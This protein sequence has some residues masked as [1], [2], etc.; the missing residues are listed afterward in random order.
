MGFFLFSFCFCF[1]NVEDQFVFQ[2]PVNPNK[3]N[4]GKMILSSAAEEPAKVTSLMFFSTSSVYL[5]TIIM[6]LCSATHNIAHIVIQYMFLFYCCLKSV[7]L[8]VLEA[9]GY[10]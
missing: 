7:C 6:Q 10:E 8:S 2:S 1:V 9:Q 5:F 3:R 4:K